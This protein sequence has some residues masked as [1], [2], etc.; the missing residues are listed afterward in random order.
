MRIQTYQQALDWFY[1]FVRFDENRKHIPGGGDL[2]RME[3]LLG[4]LGSPQRRY[5]SVIVA[6]TKGKGSTAAMLAS[7][8]RSSGYRTGFYS[9]PHLHTFRERVRV[10]D[11]LISRE[12]VVE[13]ARLLET[14]VPD[15]RDVIWFELVTALAFNWL[16]QQSIDVAILEVGLGGRLDATNVVT[17]LV[18]V[19]TPISFDHVEVLGHRLA[20]IAGEKAGVIKPGRPVISSP[21]PPDAKAVIE[22]AARER[23]S[24]LVQVGRDWHFE[25]GRANL[26][27]QSFRAWPDR[28]A[29]IA[30]AQ[31]DYIIPLLG[32]HQVSNATTALA[33]AAE[34]A[35][36]GWHLTAETA[37][38]GLQQVRWPVRFEILS[39]RP[40][41]VADGAHNRASAHELVK[42]LEMISPGKRVI[43]VFGASEDKD[44]EGMFDELAARTRLLILT[45]SKHVRAAPP[46]RLKQLAAQL[47]LPVVETDD[48][49][50]ALAYARQEAS[51]D[52]LICATGSLFVAAQARAIL[53]KEQGQTVETDED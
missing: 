27:K 11:R 8:L 22:A 15:F 29:G 51:A 43:F 48:I 2:A 25:P 4:R 18:A 3:R 32:Y 10:G 44:I 19:I 40:L 9:S 46:A 52:E 13:G 16:A 49:N 47:S 1:G 28:A 14:L 35:G 50:F 36:L 42:T 24:R 39:R 37:Q 5:P 17:P 21:Q 7:I 53:L 30:W 31:A 23:E 12:E 33:T 45:R 20:A 6:G 38:A 41:I 34:L 26:D